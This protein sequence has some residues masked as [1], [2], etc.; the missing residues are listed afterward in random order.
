MTTR[1]NPYL[2]FR[3][4]AREAMTFYHSVLGGDL[5]LTSFQEAGMPVGPDEGELI[6]HG[7]LS[8]SAGMNLMGADT[9]ASIESGPI[10]GI[11][12]SLSGDDIET[13]TEYWQALSDTGTIE[14]PFEVAPWGAKYGQC[15]DRF[16]VAW[17]INVGPEGS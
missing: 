3:G 1:L 8:T 6:M 15:T 7:H 16:G 14:I 13:L 2:H 5:L 11:T 9:P 4:D 17:M 12:M 10:G